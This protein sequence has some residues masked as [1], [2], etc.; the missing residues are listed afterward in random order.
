MDYVRNRT[1]IF[2]IGYEGL[3]V[4]EFLMKLIDEKTHVLAD[5]RANPYSQKWGFIGRTLGSFSEKLGIE[6]ASIPSLGIPSVFRKGLK[7]PEDRTELF[8]H[9]RPILIGK[10]H[11]LEALKVRSKTERIALMCFEKDPLTC[12]RHILAQELERMGA[13]VTIG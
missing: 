12:H 5:V 11:E 10:K 3:S 7:D 9:F 1:G 2:T 13:E 8:D 6:Y 4:D